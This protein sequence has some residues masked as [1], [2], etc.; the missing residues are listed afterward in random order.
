[1]F[2]SYFVHS[3]PEP[4]HLFIRNHQLTNEQCRPLQQEC[5]ETGFAGSRLYASMASPRSAYALRRRTQTSTCIEYW[6]SDKKSFFYSSCSCAHIEIIENLRLKIQNLFYFCPW[7]KN[8]RKVNY[9]VLIHFSDS[10]YNYKYL[11][12]NLLKKNDYTFE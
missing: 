4:L 7:W 8:N 10:D 11:I 9:I 2:I 5:F 1:M 6:P 3:L 12:L